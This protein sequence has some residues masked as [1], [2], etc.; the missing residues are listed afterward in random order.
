M[1]SFIL[2]ATLAAS[3]TLTACAK[4]TGE[5]PVQ[6]VS[7]LQYNSFTCNQIESEMQIVS[8]RASE[9]GGQVDSTASGDNAQMAIG[10][11]LF[12]PALF[13]LDGNT[14]QAQEYGRL[15]GEFDALEKAAVQKD[16]SI[17]VAAIQPKK[18]EPQTKEAATAYP[19]TNVRH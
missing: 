14:P 1:K 18:P 10:L 17:Q 5:I 12:W 2:P 6:Y 7:A 9:V 15:R 3:L 19:S 4:S 16:C 13:F 11:V 8:R